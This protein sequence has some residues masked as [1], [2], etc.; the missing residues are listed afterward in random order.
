[1]DFHRCR[2]T[3]PARF[4]PGGHN[5]L[6]EWGAFHDRC[7]NPVGFSFSFAEHARILTGA[8]QDALGCDR[9]N[10]RGKSSGPALLEPSLKVQ[11][12]I[13]HHLSSEVAGAAVSDNA[14]GF[15]PSHSMHLNLLPIFVTKKCIGLPQFGQFGG[16][17]FLG[18]GTPLISGGSTTLSVTDRC[19]RLSDDNSPCAF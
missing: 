7:R 8:F 10:P 6:R 14:N 16:G 11:R 1:M 4:V 5:S 2:A 13:A 17:G 18:T 15:A 19:Q 12:D 3:V 9:Y